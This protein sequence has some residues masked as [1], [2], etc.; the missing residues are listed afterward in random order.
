VPADARGEVT[1]AADVGSADMAAAPDIPPA[2]THPRR[3]V[4]R[5]AVVTSLLLHAGTLCVF[6]A[7]HGDAEVGALDQPSEAAISVEIAETRTLDAMRPQQSCEP[8][9]AP[10]ATAPV[11][12]KT[13]APDAE[14]ARQES[15]RSIEPEITV[16]RPAL[17]APDAMEE[18]M[19]AIKRETP[20]HSD[21]PPLPGAGPAETVPPPAASRDDDDDAPAKQK[22]RRQPKKTTAER[23]PKGGFTSKAKEGKGKGGDERSSASR[24]SILSYA[25]RVRA[26][27]AGNKPSGGGLHGTAV[28]AFGITASGG[29][30]YASVARSSGNASLDRLALSVVR[31]ASP[32]PQPPAGATP[33][34]LRFTIA[35]HFQ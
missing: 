29:L 4:F 35:F 33:A 1:R 25:A 28:V 11:K 22:E 8:A 5:L 10:E 23:A 7:G 9:P 19:R 16:P 27:V 15:E 13:E 12:G 18:V 31:G 2:T 17:V 20:T 14:P 32:F 6:L 34:Q 30:A 24:G 3:L 26:R 21:A